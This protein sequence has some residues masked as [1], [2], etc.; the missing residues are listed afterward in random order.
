MEDA[1]RIVTGLATKKNISPTT[2]VSDAGIGIPALDTERLAQPF[3]QVEN[4][5]TKTQQVSGLCLAIA[6]SLVELHNGSLKV[7]SSVKKGT[8]VSF[9]LPLAERDTNRAVAP[10]CILAHFNLQAAEESLEPRVRTQK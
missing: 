10:F 5:I 2:E 7:H 9:T 6:H 1:S 4:Q 3:V 8:T